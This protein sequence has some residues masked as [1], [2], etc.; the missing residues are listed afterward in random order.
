M[1]W[2]DRV[3]SRVHRSFNDGCRA[4]DVS[5][6]CSESRASAH[7]TIPYPVPIA[8]KHA[9]RILKLRR[10][11]LFITAR[12]SEICRLVL[13]FQPN[14]LLKFAVK[15]LLL[16]TPLRRWGPASKV[17]NISTARHKSLRRLRSRTSSFPSPRARRL[18]STFAFP[19]RLDSSRL[20]PT[21]SCL[22]FHGFFAKTAIINNPRQSAPFRRVCVNHC[23]LCWLLINW[24]LVSRLQTL[25]FRR[26]RVI[27]L[28]A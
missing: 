19:T 10:P 8:S 27:N 4:G 5:G 9:L 18:D 6:S 23:D 20:R 24:L 13:I 15:F 17:E 11:C 2:V 22:L 14:M 7:S 3:G 26:L 28:A 12:D 21:A 1:R 25:A 16:E